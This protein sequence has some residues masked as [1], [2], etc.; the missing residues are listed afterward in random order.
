[1]FM[2]EEVLHNKSGSEIISCRGYMRERS[3][4]RKARH[5]VTVSYLVTFRKVNKI[6]SAKFD[7][8]GKYLL[9]SLPAPTS[10]IPLD[11]DI[12]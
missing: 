6:F 4:M 7:E 9:E 2:P 1:M 12:H 11:D 5:F 8:I 3:R 10:L